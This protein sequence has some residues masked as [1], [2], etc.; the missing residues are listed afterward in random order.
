MNYTF[1]KMDLADRDVIASLIVTKIFNELMAY[2][3]S[4]LYDLQTTGLRFFMVYGPW[5]DPDMA[6]FIF[7]DAMLNDREIKVFKHGK[8]KRDFTD[9]DDIVEGVFRISRYCTL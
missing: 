5:G 9:I 6:P 4:H 1:I 3:D 2:S 8:M 7:T